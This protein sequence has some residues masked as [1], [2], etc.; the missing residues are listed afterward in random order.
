M[1]SIININVSID[2]LQNGHEVT[3]KVYLF[4]FLVKT[5]KDNFMHALFG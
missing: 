2:D 1:K 3:T 4:G 5:Q